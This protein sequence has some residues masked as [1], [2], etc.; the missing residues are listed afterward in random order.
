VRDG[1][2]RILAAVRGEWAG[3]EPTARSTEEERMA[4]K[5]LDDLLVHELE[6]IYSAEHQL[7]D[8]L[9]KMAEAA[10]S[11][12]LKKAFE[13]HKEKTERQAERLEQAFAKL[14]VK[15][16]EKMCKGMQGLIEEGQEIISE[17]AE[18]AVKDAAL[19]GAAQKVEHYEVS[20]YGTARTFA[21]TLGKDDVASLLQTTL[22]EEAHTDE[23]LTHANN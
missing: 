10:S 4:L 20:A 8:A 23:R 12:Q 6:D 19:I 11:P 1:G 5:S 22:E 7:I 18:P 9:P 3:E 17:D 16:E 21:E 15:P 2:R 14:G 13:Q